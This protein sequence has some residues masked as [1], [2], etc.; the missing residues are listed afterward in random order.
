MN[1]TVYGRATI[2]GAIR[3]AGVALMA[4]SILFAGALMVRHAGAQ[5]AWVER[6]E[7]V[8]ELKKTYA[9]EPVALGLTGDGAVIELFR[10]DDGATWTL[11]V[12][13]PNGRSRVVAFGEAWTSR[14]L[15]VKGEMS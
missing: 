12:T 11:V 8:S 7:L 9:E 13:L 5:E 4:L 1:S 15:P 3:L 14:P 2:T 6:A 10:T